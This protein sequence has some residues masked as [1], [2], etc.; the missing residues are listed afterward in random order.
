[1]AR[2]FTVA[3]LVTRAQ[4]LADMENSNFV[5]AAEWRAYCSASYAKLYNKLVQAGIAPI[6]S[7][8]TITATGAATYTLPVDWMA[9]I[10]ID[11]LSGGTRPIEMRKI[12]VREEH[13]YDTGA[14]AAQSVVYRLAGANVKLLPKPASGSYRH[15]YI[16]APIDLDD[17]ADS[18]DGISGWEQLIVLDMA[19]AA[20]IKEQ[21]SVDALQSERD[22]LDRVIDE[23][24][25]VRE[26]GEPTCISESEDSY[27]GNDEGSYFPRSG[28]R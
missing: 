19:I 20:R 7:T 6:E 24:A 13:R 23:L 14:T 26:W 9:T 17:D 3:T 18:V 8:Q 28:V 4:R 11:Y 10:R 5:V 16:P 12:S 15:L 1:M 25:P 2:S 27:A 22:S 21:S